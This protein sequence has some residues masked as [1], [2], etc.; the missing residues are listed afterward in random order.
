MLAATAALVLPACG[1]C[2]SDTTSDGV[3]DGDRVGVSLITRDSVNPYFVAMH[4]GAKEDAGRH[5]VDLTVTSGRAAD[6]EAGQIEAIQ[7]AI[8]TRQDGI[9]ITP[10]GPAVNSAIRQARDAGLYVIALG[11]PPD[12]AETVD[13]TFASDTFRAG[14]LVGQWTAAQLGGNKATIAV[15]DLFSERI[16]PL[17]D[18]RRE[19]FLAG[20][21]IDTKAGKQNG[22]AATSGRYRRGEYE[23]ICD[24][25]TQ[26][27]DDAGRSAMERCLAKSKDIN[28]VYA[29]T[30]FSANGAYE[31][32]QATGTATSPIIVSADGS[33]GG[34][35]MVKGSIIGAAAQQYPQKMAALGMQAIA[36]FAREK[37]EPTRSEGLDFVDTGVSLVTDKPVAN[38][39]SITSD[40]ASEVCWG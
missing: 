19:G 32:L 15:L 22:N 7:D 36:T 4:K 24:E 18:K 35:E 13:I 2:D 26:D 34:V 3:G 33:C 10:N 28:V 37:T 1:G 8:A 12:P 6:D 20:M 9:L 17:D 25:S 16:A 31:A 40:E 39:A 23:L 14:E 38:L 30:E 29:V 21:G 11:T 5:G 27:A